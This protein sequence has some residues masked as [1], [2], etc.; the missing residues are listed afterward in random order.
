MG[1]GRKAR[2]LQAEGWGTEGT[3]ASVEEDR[4]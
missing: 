1:M 3:G 4:G 2:V